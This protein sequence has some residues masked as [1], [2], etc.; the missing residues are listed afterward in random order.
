MLF[1]IDPLRSE[2]VYAQVMVEIRRRIARGLLK[3]GDRL[4]SVRELARSLVIN[5]NTVAKAYQLLEAEGVI[6]M[7]QGLGTFVADTKPR[8]SATVRKARV[9][10][11]IDDLFTEAYH[12]GLNA[13]SL[14]NLIHERAKTFRHSGNRERDG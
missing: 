7:R 8:L 2:A 12:M 9:A 6:T 5:P 10:R 1:K 3:S 11:L 13:E 4:P 14:E